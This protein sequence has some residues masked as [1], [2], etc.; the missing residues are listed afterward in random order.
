MK[1]IHLTPTNL[2]IILSI[3][4]F[5]IIAI[6]AT[7]AFISY[8]G[9]KEIAITV[10]HTTLDANASQNNLRILQQLQKKLE[11]EKENISRAG[12]IVAE[13]QSYQY[14]D[15]I[16]AD[17]NDY[18]GKAGV[19]ITNIDFSATTVAP[20]QPGGTGQSTTPSSP[21]PS[22]VKSMSVSV[23]L[24]NPL[25]YNSLL[26]F[27][28]SIEQNLTKMQISR[29]SLVKDSSGSVSS[30]ALAIEVYVR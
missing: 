26:R 17:L 14:Q 18:A 19:E 28:N 23:A 24:K 25:N 15:Q 9:L 22:G 3:S 7:L 27:L 12:S 2:R 1:K 11:E 20:T 10:S 8:K 5:V 4:L 16:I 13:S 21:P 6:G 29:V 30:E